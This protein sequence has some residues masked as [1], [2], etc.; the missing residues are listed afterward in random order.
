[1]QSITIRRPDDF[2]VHVRSGAMMCDLVR[3]TARQFARAIIMPN[4]RPPVRTVEEARRYREE[5]LRAVDGMDFEPLMTLYLTDA[6]STAEISK[7]RKSGFIHGVKLYPSGATTNSDSGVTDLMALDPVLAA[8]QAEEMPLLVHGEV[9]DKSV[10]VFDRETAFLQ[11]YLRHVPERFEKLRI[12]FE[13]ITTAAAVEYVMR[14]PDTV[15]A[16]ITPHHLLWNRNEIFR[17][18]LRPHAYCLPVLKREED[19]QA[20]LG[21]AASG[22]PRFFC[23]TDSA[24]HERST[25]ESSCGCAGI[26]NAHAAVELYALAFERAGALEKLEG[27]LSENGAR[28]YGLPLNS[29]TITLNQVPQRVPDHYDFGAQPVVP[30]FAGETIPWSVDYAV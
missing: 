16:T 13:H 22:S 27:F 10:D 1:M 2:H 14:A 18:G 12:V 6:T 3:H 24:P 26:Y 7:A 23:G 11:S 19:R 4:L 15:A 30:M 5:I 17:G 20:L 25:K 28:F 29:R 8:M 9:T 21:A